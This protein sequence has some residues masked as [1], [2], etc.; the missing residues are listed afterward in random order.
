MPMSFSAMLIPCVALL[1]RVEDGVFELL[2]RHVVR[3]A[4]GLQLLVEVIEWLYRPLVRYLAECTR[5][6][7]QD[8]PVGL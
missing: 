1:D 6:L 2:Q 4:D 3:I 8:H 7:H 5:H